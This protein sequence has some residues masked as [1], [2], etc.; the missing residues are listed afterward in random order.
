MPTVGER[1]RVDSD[2]MSEPSDDTAGYCMLQCST[3]TI[4]F[5]MEV[6]SVRAADCND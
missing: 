3:Y 2:L 1:Q 5:H 4:Y 6:I